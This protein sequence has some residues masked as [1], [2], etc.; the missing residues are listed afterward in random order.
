MPLQ[1]DSS[2]PW[3]LKFFVP[4]LAI[5]LFTPAARTQGIQSKPASTDKLVR[6][7][8]LFEP[9]QGQ[10]QPHARFVAH[11]AGLSVSLAP[12]GVDLVV[13]ARR[14]NLQVEFVGSSKNASIT[15]LEKQASYTNYIRGDDPSRW[16]SHIPNFSRV[17]YQGIYPGIEAIFYGNGQDLE[18]DFV[19]APGADYRL[20]RLHVGGPHRLALQ[21]NGNIV[22]SL[23]GGQMV[24]K[25]PEIYQ[26]IDGSR[27]LR[28]GRF[29][30]KGNHDFSFIVA[31]YDPA[32]PLII[33]PVLV[34]SSYLANDSVTMAGVAS[35]SAGDTYVTG[36]T[37]DPIFPV[38]SP[39]IQSTC[40][41]CAGSAAPDVFV[42]KFN[43]S[44]TNLLFSTFLGGNNY[45][46]SYGIAV[47]STGGAV[48]TGRTSSTDFPLKNP[49]S[50]ITPS[51]GSYFPFISSLSPDGS[52]LIYSSVLGGGTPF[53]L[54]SA[55]ALDANGNAYVT[56]ITESSTFPVTT[57]AYD[58]IGAPA[59]P[60]FVAF[61]SKFL[62]TGALSYSALIG[63]TEGP[64]G[65]SGPSGPWAIAVDSLGSAYISGGAG[66]DW[67]TSTGAYQTSIPAALGYA[68]PYVTKL[69]PDGSGLVYSTYVGNGGYST[70]I[71]LDANDD[72]FVTGPYDAAP[73]A[74]DFPTTPNAYQESIGNSCCSSFFG[75]ISPDGSSLLYASY[76]Y[77]DTIPGNSTTS[78]TGIALDNSGDI[79]LS[80]YTTS[81][82][83]PLANPLQSLPGTSTFKEQTGFI[84]RFD[85]TGQTLQFSS[86]YGGIV[87][88]GTIV[89]LAVD[90]QNRL[91]IAGTT[92]AGLFTT[93]GAYLPSV[94][95]PP[96]NYQYTYPYAAVIDADTAAPSL[97]FTPTVLSFGAIEVGSS[98]QP[99]SL[100][101]KNCGNDTLTISSVQS[102]DPTF[103][104]P[105]ASN[106]C[107]QSVAPGSSCTLS[108]VFSPTALTGVI[109]T[110]LINSNAAVSQTPLSLSGSG[111]A[112]VINVTPRLSFDP[113]FIGETSIAF[114]TN[115]TNSGGIPLVLDFSHT[116]ISPEFAYKQNNCNMPILPGKS[117]FLLFTFTPQAAGTRTGTMQIASNDPAHPLVS[118]MLTGVGLDTYP[119][120]SLASLSTSAVVA[121]TSQLSINIT[122]SN[123]FG[124]SQVFVGGA[125]QPT[126]YQGFTHLQLTV[127]AALL[128]AAGELQVTVVNPAPGGGVSNPLTLTVYQS[129]PVSANA[130]VA[131][132]VSGLLFASVGTTASSNPNTI[133]V[134]DPVATSVKQYI[135]VGNDPHQLALSDDGQYLYVALNGDHSIQRI[136]LSSFALEKTFALPVDSTFGQLTVADMK[137]VP[138][139]PQSVVAALF[140]VASPAEDGIALFNDGGLVNWLPDQFSTNYASVDSFAFAGNP[141][142]IYSEPLTVL[143]PTFGVFS[144]TSAGITEQG[145]GPFA[146][147]GPLIVSDGTLLY[148]ASGQVWNPPSTL[149]GT[150]TPAPSLAASI[151]PDRSLERTFFLDPYSGSGSEVDA[152]DQTTFSFL[153]SVAFPLLYHPDV[154]GL[155]RWGSDG[156]AFAVGNSV[157]AAGTG[158]VILFHSALARSVP[159]TIPAP[160]LSSLNTPAVQEGSPSFVLSVQGS[161]FVLGA[162]ID[163]NG[164]PR[165]TTF[166]SP[167]QL[168]ALIPASDISQ[169]GSAQITAV[170]PNP[171]G[172]SAALTL[173][174]SAASGPSAG[175]SSTSISFVAQATGSS[176]SPQSVTLQN[177][178]TAALNISGIQASG[179]FGQTNNCAASLAPQASC[180]ISI[181][182]SPTV[183]GSRSGSVTISDDASDSPQSVALSG[184]GVAPDFS[185]PTGGGSSTNTNASVSSGQTATYTLSISSVA[186]STGTVSLTCA[187]V[188]ANAV[189][190]INPPSLTLTAGAPVTFTVTVATQTSQAEAVPLPRL[191]L[192][193]IMLLA[194]CGIL[195]T[196]LAY[197]PCEARVRRNICLK[198]L[199][200]TALIAVALAGCGGGGSPG[201]GDSPSVVK[202][203]P[204]TYTVNI[205]AT[206]GGKSH[207][208]PLTL[209]VQ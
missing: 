66:S 53:D 55:V 32:Q 68:A 151:V 104:V 85:P 101:V 24:F 136:N 158:Q 105:A 39:V 27:I 197:R 170:N 204:G 73:N 26:L 54:A 23:S 92:G 30:L 205:V 176:S 99:H 142:L 129:V 164:S 31:N 186:G 97:C 207:T 44:G 196:T 114:A 172:A 50:Q 195:L 86:Y 90:S 17:S 111:A 106:G 46:Q 87:Q 6:F 47:N 117:C 108:V 41:S 123:F 21:S 181:T 71:A 103:A 7:P 162:T 149:V 128:T 83:F 184:T 182:F 51:N 43:P 59:Y 206:L 138:G 135:P 167:T 168:S 75:E 80:G 203:Q 139:S 74:N 175:V 42:S 133:A 179:D 193:A 69:T 20:I 137:V 95:P 67:P 120:P 119:V 134:I 4:L 194:A 8:I 65:L 171:G 5:G 3:I 22:V 9:N 160:V 192:I 60:N 62:T 16:L 52:T 202:V 200:A 147:G 159:S 10:A 121:G 81:A 70:G 58:P 198:Y 28:E 152:Y 49:I 183:A 173:Q 154:L 190:T 188:P 37:F 189:C 140:R 110:L 130:L 45:D 155:N 48:V 150:Y 64:T 18:H 84:S 98:S 112:P 157:P 118:I 61:V 1:T 78:T 143:S 34:F 36:L 13:G 166:V 19:V 178:G 180:A 126:T 201:S 109:A 148:A 56:G 100:T 199:G 141:A 145:Q 187:Q 161:S 131:D 14:A 146:S 177:N 116:T 12:S 113:E 125:A 82:K 163:W 115:V 96:P 72:A 15:P 174:I 29:V 77:G 57:N 209:T 89:G 165:S 132:P 40:S 127:P 122:G 33:D 79:W 88:G 11:S 107:Q 94:T 169:P 2:A 35:D 208:A 93:P 25:K 63:N 38:T 76:F 144:V 191:L 124:A 185:F 153:G 91:H 102:T 156:F